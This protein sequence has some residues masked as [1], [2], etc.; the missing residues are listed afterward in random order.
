MINDRNN[1]SFVQF[2]DS[3]VVSRKQ[4]VQYDVVVVVMVVV[5]V[6]ISVDFTRFR[7]RTFRDNAIISTKRRLY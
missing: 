2:S 3:L 4:F 7:T 1:L 6:A 5:T